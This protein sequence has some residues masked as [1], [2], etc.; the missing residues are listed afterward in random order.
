MKQTVQLQRIQ[1]KMRPGVITRDGFLG[2]DRRNLVGRPDKV[3]VLH[4]FDTASSSASEQL[5]AARYAE[6]VAGDQMVEVLLIGRGESP[7]AVAGWA[8]SNGLPTEHLYFD[9]DGRTG[10]LIGVRR[11]PESLI[12]DPGGRLAHQAR[13]PMSWSAGALGKRIEVIKRGVEEID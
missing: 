10:D 3:L 12:Y 1:E 5:Q 13:G 4:W 11:Y 8:E 2:S 7:S 9:K 6:S